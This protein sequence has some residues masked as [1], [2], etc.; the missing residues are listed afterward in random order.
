[1]AA[2]RLREP[3]VVGFPDRSTG[4]HR[5]EVMGLV[6]RDEIL[7]R[8]FEQPLDAGRTLE[9]VDAS[10]Q[11]VIGWR[12]V[13]SRGSGERRVQRLES[14]GRAAPHLNAHS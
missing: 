1:M 13:N 3:I 9:S 4:T 2:Q 14:W 5:S 10:D 12:K 7:L 6:E 11:A 8:R